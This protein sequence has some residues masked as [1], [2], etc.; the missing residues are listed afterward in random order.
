MVVV[1]MKRAKN[2]RAEGPIGYERASL[3]NVALSGKFPTIPVRAGVR[4]VRERNG[5]DLGIEP[6][7]LSEQALEGAEPVV[8]NGKAWIGVGGCCILTAPGLQQIE[9]DE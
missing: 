5:F 1:I 8:R 3:V 9:R 6:L 2:I 4:A 7:R